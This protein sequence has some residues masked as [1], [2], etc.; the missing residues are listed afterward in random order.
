MPEATAEGHLG[1]LPAQRAQQLP[2]DGDEV[3][4]GGSG[5]G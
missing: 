4:G 2:A 3:E 1:A 5:H